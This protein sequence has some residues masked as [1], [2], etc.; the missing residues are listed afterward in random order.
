MFFLARRNFQNQRVSY[1]S[2]LF[3]SSEMVKE[4]R[5]GTTKSKRSSFS[6]GPTITVVPLTAKKP[7]ANDESAVPEGG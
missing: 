1:L 5:K 6:G 2:A 3:G 4:S 7:P